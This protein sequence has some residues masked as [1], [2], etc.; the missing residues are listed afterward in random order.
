[1]LLI[2]VNK[3]YTLHTH[4]MALSKRIKVHVKLN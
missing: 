2:K 4:I 1:L 3:I